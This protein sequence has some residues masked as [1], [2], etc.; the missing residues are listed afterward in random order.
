MSW[1]PPRMHERLPLF[2]SSLPIAGKTPLSSRPL[3]FPNVCCP[4]P[5]VCVVFIYIFPNTKKM[6]A[7]HTPGVKTQ[8]HT[9]P[10]DPLFKKKKKKNRLQA[11][12]P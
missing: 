8:E 12:T 11:E 2:G 10:G 9:V 7:R 5:G 4:L 3:R 6:C 1:R